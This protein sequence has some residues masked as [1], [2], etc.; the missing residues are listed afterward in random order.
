MGHGM[1]LNYAKFTKRGFAFGLSLFLLGAFGDSV[2]PNLLGELPSWGQSAFFG[3][4]VC[5]IVVGFFSVFGFGLVLPL[6]D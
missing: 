6:T 2:G 3:F 5:G 1:R 4:M